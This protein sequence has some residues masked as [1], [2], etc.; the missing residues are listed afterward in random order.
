MNSL[1]ANAKGITNNLSAINTSL[2][3]SSKKYIDTVVNS[4][5]LLTYINETLLV[6]KQH[7]TGIVAM[8]GEIEQLKKK[9][10]QQG[11]KV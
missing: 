1:N 9:V 2:G 7:I 6:D 10:L 8:L 11:E 5:D 3:E 4:N